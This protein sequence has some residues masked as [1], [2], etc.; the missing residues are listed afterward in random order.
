MK[1]W[2]TSATLLLL[3][4]CACSDK[5]EKVGLKKIVGGL[6]HPLFLTSAPG[7]RSRLFIVEK[8]GRIRVLR[9]GKLLPR[10]FLDITKYVWWDLGEMGFMGLAFHPKY[11]SNGYF[12][13]HYTDFLRRIMVVRYKR[14][15]DPDIAD[16]ESGKIILKFRQPTK[17]H[18]GGMLLF[19][20]DNML[21]IGLGDGGLIG[22]PR[23]FAQDKGK[24]HGTILRIDV[25]H[26]DPYSVPENNPFTHD[27]GAFGEIWFLGLRNPYRFS[28]DR[29]TNLLYIGD[30]GEKLLEE[31]DVIPSTQGGANF[32]WNIMEGTNCFT[33]DRRHMDDSRYTPAPS[34]DRTGLILPALEYSHKE[35]CAVIGGFVYRGN[36]LRSIQ[37][38]YF[39][40]DY[41]F[42][43]IRSFRFQD[44]LAKDR[45]QWDLGVAGNVLSFGEDLEHNLYV[46]YE[47]GNVYRF[48]Q[49]N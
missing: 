41:C 47:E 43:W 32:G 45:K 3:C 24:L 49:R 19:G 48:V 29:K 13:I 11:E 25:D 36:E 39:Y 7:D 23:E 20:P 12:Y 28:I 18:H 2:K 27:P 34:C 9:D 33:K 15:A 21:Y 4:F 17:H 22:D 30:T 26:G 5:S 37:G 8:S 35:G 14:S 31:I 46:L 1:A 10:P 40:G 38:H 6:E 16:P 42:G 44:G